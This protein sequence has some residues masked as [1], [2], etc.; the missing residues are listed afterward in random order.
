MY[1]NMIYSR[2]NSLK[3]KLKSEKWTYFKL[4]SMFFSKYINSL[5]FLL[6]TSKAR[7]GICCSSSKV[8]DQFSMYLVHKTR[9]NVIISPSQLEAIIEPFIN[10]YRIKGNRIGIKMSMFR[11]IRFVLLFLANY[12][13]DFFLTIWHWQ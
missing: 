1:I 2:N 7:C 5:F 3:I 4:S 8:L 13:L 12:F 6:P 10:F 11:T 9:R